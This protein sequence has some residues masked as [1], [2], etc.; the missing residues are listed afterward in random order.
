IEDRFSKWLEKDISS[1][2]YVVEQK[3]TYSKPASNKR[4]YGFV[5]ASVIVA[6]TIGIW[7]FNTDSAPIEQTVE[8]FTDPSEAVLPGKNKAVLTLSDG[9]EIFLEEGREQTV[10]D[11]SLALS[12]EG[13]TLDYSAQQALEVYQHKLKV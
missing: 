6:I 7:F 11:G 9:T 1:D 4:K 12:A 8:V 10:Q 2:W 13:N 5:A 3:A